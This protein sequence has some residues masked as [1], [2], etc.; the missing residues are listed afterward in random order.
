MTSF[1]EQQASVEVE[2]S[3]IWS[4]LFKGLQSML[5]N[6]NPQIS[7][8][9]A[10]LASVPENER[11]HSATTLSLSSEQIEGRSQPIQGGIMLQRRM[12]LEACLS[13]T[14]GTAQ[15]FAAAVQYL[16]AAQCLLTHPILP[17]AK[18]DDQECFDYIVIGAGSSGSVV[19]SRLS[20]NK[21]YKVLLIEAGPDAPLEADIPGT[22]T[23][24]MDSTYDWKYAA[25]NNGISSQGLING[26][27]FWSRGKMFGGCSSINAMVY[28]KG[29]DQDYQ[30]WYD[31]GNKE[32][33]VEESSRLAKLAPIL[34]ALTILPIVKVPYQQVM[35]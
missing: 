27:V 20:E 7:N 15:S 11:N 18:V 16:A 13:S 24:L 1:G 22:E 32:W 10:A 25:E 17:D 3:S 28:V 26:S 9:K 6:V 29:N 8:F 23:S 5:H 12:S 21:D 33:S 35:L 2:T 34:I 14:S 4:G 31:A 19:A 30:T